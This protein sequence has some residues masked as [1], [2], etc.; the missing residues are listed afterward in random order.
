MEHRRMRDN[1]IQIYKFL[2]DID[3]AEATI[4]FTQAQ[5]ENSRGHSKQ[6]FN[7]NRVYHWNRRMS[8]TV[9]LYVKYIT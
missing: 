1:M 5:K 9:L 8:C 7:Y 4:C 2:K 6:M 3:R